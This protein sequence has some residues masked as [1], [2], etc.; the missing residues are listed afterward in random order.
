MTD[1]GDRDSGCERHRSYGCLLLRRLLA[2]L[3]LVLLL[4]PA[5]SVHAQVA[6]RSGI[7]SDLP[8]L[9]LT[10]ST[11]AHSLGGA[12]WP[13]GGHAL[14]HHPALMAGQGF[15]ITTGRGRTD[16]RGLAARRGYRDEI[17]Y[18]ALSTSTNWMGGSLAVGMSVFDYGLTDYVGAV[19]YRRDVKFGIEMGAVAKVVVQSAGGVSGRTGAFDVGLSQGFGRL[20][21]A[22]TVQNMGPGLELGGRHRD[23][24]LR[25]VL[26][27][28]TGG[29]APVGPLDIGAAAQIAYERGGE[30][31]PGGGIEIAYWPIQRRVFIV[32]IGAVRVVDGD[33]LPLTFGAGFEGDRIRLDYGYGNRDPVTGPHRFGVSIR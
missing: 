32:R 22:L 16:S 4:Q 9:E 2:L 25:V 19:G 15:E 21:A 14:F 11:R 17:L 10:T 28:G 29:R 33:D 7:R 31:V 3:P 12:F 8:I 5:T 26:G 30:I 20:T 24:P 23:L 1:R 6:G 27:A 18:A 13:G